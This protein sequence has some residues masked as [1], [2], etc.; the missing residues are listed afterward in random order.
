MKKIFLILFLLI[1]VNA[2]S[3]GFKKYDSLYTRAINSTG[4]Y[5]NGVLQTF[6]GGGFD[7]AAFLS[8][9]HTWTKNFGM[10]NTFGFT[11]TSSSIKS[12]TDTLVYLGKA[13]TFKT[14]NGTYYGKLDSIIGLQLYKDL[15]FSKG[16]NSWIKTTD[17]YALYLGTNS[18]SAIKI[19]SLNNVRFYENVTV[20]GDITVSGNVNG[21]QFIGGDID[22]D[23]IAGTVITADDG[24]GIQALNGSNVS[25]GVIKAGRLSDSVFKLSNLDTTRF[26]DLSDTSKYYHIDTLQTENIKSVSNFWNIISFYATANINAV[27]TFVTS[28]IF[29]AVVNFANGLTTTTMTASGTVT[30]NGDMVNN[31]WKKIGSASSRDQYLRDTMIRQIAA[32]VGSTVTTA[33]GIPNHYS[34]V[35]WNVLIVDDSLTLLP[36][37]NWTSGYRNPGF[38]FSIDAT[39]L[40]YFT[41]LS[42]YSI[43]GDTLKWY[44]KYTDYNR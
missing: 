6:S 13:S 25:T 16:S 44:I 8:T 22:A 23:N 28:P 4:Y 36:G 21:V 32:A 43:P 5:L 17:N 10:T 20:D 9:F 41:P 37:A 31:G 11:W 38:S 35:S 40:K 7:S 27:F 2:F 29:S 26:L 18:D 3:Q 33:H 1:S 42:A 39:N 30:F 24:S 19:D 34:I 12:Q 14:N 15:Q